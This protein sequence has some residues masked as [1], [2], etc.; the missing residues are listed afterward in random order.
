[1]KY[2]LGKYIQTIC[3]FEKDGDVLNGMFQ[4]IAIV[5][6]SFLIWGT[7]GRYLITKRELVEHFIYVSNEVAV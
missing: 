6:D 4:I 7:C 1:M 3:G 2:L 5:G